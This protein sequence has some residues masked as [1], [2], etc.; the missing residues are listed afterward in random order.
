MK[1]QTLC[2]ECMKACGKCPWSDGSFTPVDGWTATPTKIKNDDVI[3]DSYL[4][5]KCPLFIS[6][7][8]IP[9]YTRELSRLL[10]ISDRTLF[11]WSD[12][13]KILKARQ[14]GYELKIKKSTGIKK[15][16]IRK[17]ERYG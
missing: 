12:E 1:R 6:D 16:F 14:F 13:D 5:K 11:R 2:W 9:I 17:V 15:M 8:W 4:V 10:K 7:V 3:T